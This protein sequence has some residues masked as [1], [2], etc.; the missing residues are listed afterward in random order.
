VAV[1]LRPGG[2]VTMTGV[3]LVVVAAM[4]WALGSFFSSRLPM[5]GDAVTTTGIQALAGGLLLLPVSLVLPDDESLDP[6]S[7]SSRSLLGLAYL[8]VF[9]SIIGYTAY[10]LLNVLGTAHL[11]VREPLV[12]IT[13][14]VFLRSRS[15][16]MP[17]R[18]V[19]LSSVSVVIRHESPRRP[20]D[21]R[22]TIVET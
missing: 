9:G 5:P 4:A 11:R 7:W 20:Q 1:L 8:I 15:R 6:A 14:G 21:A 18:R 12:A 19:I 13:L 17:W 3:L 10:G 16:R 22:T 2:G